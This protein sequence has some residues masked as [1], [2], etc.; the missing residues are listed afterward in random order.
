MGDNPF[1]GNVP[2]RAA[3]KDS[4]DAPTAGVP[5]GRHHAGKTRRQRRNRDAWHTG[6]LHIKFCVPARRAAFFCGR[7]STPPGPDVYRPRQPPGAAAV[8][9]VSSAVPQLKRRGTK[10]HKCKDAKTRAR[11]ARVRPGRVVSFRQAMRRFSAAAAWPW[12]CFVFLR[13]SHCTIFQMTML[14]DR[15]YVWNCW[16]YRLAPE[17]GRTAGRTFQAGIPGL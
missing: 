13:L 8:R 4:A 6:I 17:H 16:I 11:P 5:G 2:K 1:S 15:I 9:P 10:I 14:G 12:Y 3:S 7:C